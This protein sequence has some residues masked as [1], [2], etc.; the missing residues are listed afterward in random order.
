MSHTTCD[1]YFSF[2]FI[3]ITPTKRILLLSK[4]VSRTCFVC[5]YFFNLFEKY[6]YKLLLNSFKIGAIVTLKNLCSCFES[7]E[8][9]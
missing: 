8:L 3:T 9:V 7:F 1:C 2:D 4:P 6:I 5:S